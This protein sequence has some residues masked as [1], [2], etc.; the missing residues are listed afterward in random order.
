MFR[1]WERSLL[2]IE[3]NS[4][5]VLTVSALRSWHS[6]KYLRTDSHSIDVRC[7]RA[8]FCRIFILCRNIEGWT[9]R[10][11]D[12][13]L[14]LFSPFFF[15]FSLSHFYSACDRQLSS[16]EMTDVHATVDSST[17]LNSNA[18]INRIIISVSVVA[19]ASKAEQDKQNIASFGI[20]PF[21]L[22]EH[23]MN[24]RTFKISNIC[25]VAPD[26]QWLYLTRQS[27]NIGIIRAVFPLVWFDL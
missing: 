25:S 12:F 19:D 26:P 13:F 14:P 7:F 6:A 24:S 11:I 27:I 2:W 17:E 23:S 3:I 8:S 9:W 18:L 16:N 1:R 21:I 15:F 4:R 5:L 20:F 22:G 10:S